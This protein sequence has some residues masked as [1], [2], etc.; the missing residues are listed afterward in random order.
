VC[1]EGQQPFDP[2]VGRTQL[3]LGPVDDPPRY[4]PGQG[5]APNA[6]HRLDLLEGTPAILALPAGRYWLVNTNGAWIT[7]R[8][9]STVLTDIQRG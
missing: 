3:L 8:G 2:S 9:C 7:A 1:S 6:T 4:E 5:G